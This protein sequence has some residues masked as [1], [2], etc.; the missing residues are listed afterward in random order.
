MKPYQSS[1]EAGLLPPAR[2]Q[3]SE[4]IQDAGEEG[5]PPNGTIAGQSLAWQPTCEKTY[6]SML[7]HFIAFPFMEDTH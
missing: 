3:L 7:W 1:V 6:E 5:W 2:A 4:V